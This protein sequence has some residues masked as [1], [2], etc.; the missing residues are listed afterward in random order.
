[1]KAQQFLAELDNDRTIGSMIDAISYYELEAMEYEKKGVT[2]SPES[3]SSHLM[4]REC[5]LILLVWLVKLCV[6]AIDKS[7]DEQDE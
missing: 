1:M 7:Y 5:R 3:T 4:I 6:G 2:L